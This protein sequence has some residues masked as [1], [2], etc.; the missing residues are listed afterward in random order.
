[1]S[2]FHLVGSVDQPNTAGGVSFR[3]FA[4]DLRVSAE[5]IVL[6][7]I[8]IVGIGLR[9]AFLG[10]NSFWFDEAVVDLVA[11]AKWQDILL[12][13]R[14]RD[15][16]PPLYYLLMK[17]WVGLVG[18]GEAA[19]RVPSACF[20][21]ASVSLTYALTRQVSPR[22]RLTS[23]LLVSTAPIEIWTG[24]M[25]RM[26]AFLG[27][28][29]LG[30]TLILVQGVKHHQWKH[31]AAYAAVATLMVYTHNLAFFV[32][33]AH[34]LWVASYERWHLGRWLVAMAA[35]A[36][37]YTPW[38]S[39]LWYQATHLDSFIAPFYGD[40][41]PYLKLSD[42]FGLF[43][44]GGSLFGMPSYHF[45]N[46]ALTLL[47]Q[48]LLLLPFLVILGAAFGS[49]SRDGRQLAL[50]GLPFA[51]PVGIMQ[52]LALGTPVFV[53]RWFAFLFPFYAVLVAEGAF[54][55]SRHI[56]GHA[57]RTVA[58]I[59]AWLLLFNLAG[60]DRYFFDPALHPYHWRSAVAG[61]EREIKPD[62]LLLFGD[63]GNEIA[64]AYYFKGR[65]WTMRLMPVPDF[66]AIRRLGTRYRRVWLI[67]APPADHPALLDQTVAALRT[68]FV[69]ADRR[70]VASGVYP[71]IYRFDANSASS[72]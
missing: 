36:V 48:L 40:K 42:L 29:A 23:A 62:D 5:A 43:A 2:R 18:T 31:W 57:D 14:D 7:A 8:L 66:A 44:F 46:T 52:L 59:I 3:L 39:S 21:L 9:F 53:A 49:P 61:V 15:T 65:A 30:S 67:V 71:W 1:M 10:H 26:Y 38:V 17:G 27:A 69:L 19:L 45:S 56:R 22:V 16:H 11:K 37:F 34:G 25:A 4:T 35:V 50:V 72:P 6:A 68:S 28:L 24:Q 55:L 12:I 47:E 13:L 32:L 60:L 54:A 70:R 58:G 64:F 33:L 63:Q 41:P 51:V 20:S